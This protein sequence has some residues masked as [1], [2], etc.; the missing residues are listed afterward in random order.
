M[1]K[2]YVKR[3]VPLPCKVLEEKAEA[4]YQDGILKV[5]IPKLKEKEKKKGTKV[6]VKSKKS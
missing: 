6:K 2:G 1:S 5:V 3:V 4:N